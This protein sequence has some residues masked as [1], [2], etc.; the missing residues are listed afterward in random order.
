MAERGGS[1]IQELSASHASFVSQPEAATQLI[2][3]A[4]KLAT[5]P[6][7]TSQRDGGERL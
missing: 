6:A 2:L 1:T 3:T 5:R 7:P 4:V